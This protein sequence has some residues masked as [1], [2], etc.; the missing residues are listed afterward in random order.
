MGRVYRQ[1]EVESNGTKKTA[2]AIVDTGADETVISEKFATQLKAMLYG[3]YTAK[4]A[5]QT[6]LTGKYADLTIDEKIDYEKRVLFPK[7]NLR[8][9][10]GVNILKK[11][12][13]SFT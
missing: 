2:I 11:Y 6:T 9:K 8:E 3:I 1:V 10:K 4:C 7:I 5:S 12:D 13:D